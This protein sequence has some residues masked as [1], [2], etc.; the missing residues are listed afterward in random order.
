MRG[1]TTWKKQL[2]QESWKLT[3]VDLKKDGHKC[4]CKHVHDK[5]AI[6]VQMK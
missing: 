4:E 1:K 3:D 6:S 5:S 2:K